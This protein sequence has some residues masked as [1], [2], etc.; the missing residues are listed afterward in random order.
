MKRTRRAPLPQ[1]PPESSACS[2][3]PQKP[4]GCAPAASE[5]KMLWRPVAQSPLVSQECYPSFPT[6]CCSMFI[7]GNLRSLRF[8]WFRI[9]MKSRRVV[10]GGVPEGAR[11]SGQS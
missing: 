10:V 3:G 1:E 9:E 5:G 2:G 8:S 6:F 4:A 7:P 11:E